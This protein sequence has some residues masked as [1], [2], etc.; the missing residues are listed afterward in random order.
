MGSNALAIAPEKSGDGVTRLVS[1]AHQPWRGGVAWYEAVV[2]SGEGLHFAGATFPGSPYL[3][4]GH[5]ENIGW[6][7]TVNRPDMVDVYRLTVNDAGT[8]YR[9]GDEWLPLEKESVR[10]GVR[11]GP[12]V[13]PI[14]RDVYRSVH[15]PV[16]RNDDGYFAIRYG[17]MGSIRSVDA[18][19]RLQKAQ[20]YD[21]WY[22]VLSRQHIP[23]TNFIYADKAGNIAYIYN[24]AI[25]DRPRGYDWRGT[26]PGD[27]P[28]AIWQALVPYS[29][30]PQYRN[31][32]SGYLYNANNEP[33]HAAGPSDLSPDSVPPEMGVELT[34]TNRA[35]RA[36]TLLGAADVVDGPTLEA[37]KYD[38]RYERRD[39]IARLF[40]AIAAL[41][42]SDDPLL[43]RAQA[44][45]A[46][47]DFNA[48]G[49]GNA[50]SLA[51]LIIRDAMSADYNNGAR[52][53]ARAQLQD[54][55]DHLMRHWGRIDVPQS[56][57]LRLRQGQPGGP[58]AVDLPLDGG[59]DTLRA[60][61]SW[62]V[63]DDGRLAV[64][65]GDSFV[66]F[67]EWAPGEPVRSTS[68]QPFGQSI[69]RPGS[70][71]F[72]DQAPLFVMHKRKPVH[73]TRADALRNGVR[74]YTV[75]SR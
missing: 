6:T 46:R 29:A 28:A 65:H 20:S 50:D 34:M 17:G 25:P 55:V 73:F 39:Y 47:W 48:D 45:L 4:L 33:F 52:P 18:Y 19:Y 72:S 37:I 31:P 63:D 30:L 13:L 49:A 10:M 66:M 59:S 75:S 64:K 23:S 44:M 11:F 27:D 35:W 8:R 21:E 41:D 58:N 60:S 1:N 14:W 36:H 26:L 7:N 62:D 57:V 61:T 22:E 5:N 71:H 9:L 32:A 15:G 43:T 42:V 24:A 40:D 53:D 70:P 38:T 56:Q 2:E 12:L 67:V 3:F 69:T 68:I 16:I 54:A 51:L 74:R